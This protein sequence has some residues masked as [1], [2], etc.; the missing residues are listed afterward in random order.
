MSNNEHFIPLDDPEMKTDDTFDMKILAGEIRWIE[1]KDSEAERVMLE[2]TRK[3]DDRYFNERRKAQEGLIR[4]EMPDH[5][6]IHLFETMDI[7]EIPGA[8]PT[9]LK[10]RGVGA[11]KGQKLEWV[12]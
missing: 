11:I 12:Y 7:F 4:E 3:L 5:D 2:V 10:G 1:M 9:Q 6:D 8:P